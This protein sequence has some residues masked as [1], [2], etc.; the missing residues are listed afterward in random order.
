MDD[1]LKIHEKFTDR[2]NMSVAELES[3]KD[4]KNY[5]E[6]QERKSG[7][8][9]GTEPIDD[10]ITLMETPASQWSCDDDGFNECEEANEL[11]SFTSRM[12]AVNRGDDIP[13][14]DPGVSKRD[15]SLMA[16]GVDP[17]PGTEDFMGDRDLERESDLF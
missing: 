1:P 4:S 5:A 6:Y 13:D 14:T 15:M 9:E 3:L 17:N 8:Q 12:S 10:A 11:L 16:W 2:V 7:G